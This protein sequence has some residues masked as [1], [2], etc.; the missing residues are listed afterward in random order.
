LFAGPLYEVAF[1][2]D[3]E[4]HIVPKY[5]W[6]ASIQLWIQVLTATLIVMV[7]AIASSAT[8]PKQA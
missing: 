7:V 4:T 8:H 1:Y 3:G 2:H 5:H 6:W